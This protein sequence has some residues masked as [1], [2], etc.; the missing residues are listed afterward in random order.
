M[1]VVFG[2]PSAEHVTI[3][4]GVP[5]SSTGRISGG[6]RV[7]LMAV[8]SLGGGREAAPRPWSGCLQIH[9]EDLELDGQRRWRHK[10]VQD[11]VRCAGIHRFE[12]FDEA[13]SSTLGDL[14]VVVP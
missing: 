11:V 5:L 6:R 3:T 7:I 9:L 8:S 12:C 13:P 1:T 2:F 14:G 10:R 4:A